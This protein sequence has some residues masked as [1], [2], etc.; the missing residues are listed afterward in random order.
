MLSAVVGASPLHPTDDSER[1]EF[2]LGLFAIEAGLVLALSLIV[3]TRDAL[4]GADRAKDQFLAAITH[5]LRNPLNAIAGW[6][7]QLESRP[8][9]VD[10]TT[11]AARAIQHAT[12]LERSAFMHDS[13][14]PNAILV[15]PQ[16]SSRC[17]M[18]QF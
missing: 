5:D 9:D 6:A 11:R 4:Q 2:A 15:D 13:I 18:C 12:A 8:G 17:R 10:F 1:S 7:S 16:A 14:R 3:K